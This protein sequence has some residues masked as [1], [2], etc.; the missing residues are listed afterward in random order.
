MK[1]DGDKEGKHRE[2][3]GEASLHDIAHRNDII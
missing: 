2:K 1:E 3:D